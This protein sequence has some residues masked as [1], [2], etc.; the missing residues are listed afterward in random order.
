MDVDNLD[1][2]HM[3]PVFSFELAEIRASTDP[4][5]LELQA[6]VQ[7]KVADVVARMEAHFMGVPYNTT[8]EREGDVF[9]IIGRPRA[10]WPNM[11]LPPA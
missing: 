7:A 1:M 6:S 11:P 5:V 9:R 3:R 8:V 2:P 10:P 4:R